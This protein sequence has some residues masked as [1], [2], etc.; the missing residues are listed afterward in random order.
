MWH[1]SCCNDECPETG[2]W[3]IGSYNATHNT[4]TRC[5]RQVNRQPI[6]TTKEQIGITSARIA[7]APCQKSRHVCDGECRCP[8]KQSPLKEYAIFSKTNWSSHYNA[9]AY[10]SE[11]IAFDLAVITTRPTKLLGDKSAIADTWTG[12]A[13]IVSTIS[14]RELCGILFMPSSNQLDLMQAVREFTSWREN[15][16]RTTNNTIIQNK[17]LFLCCMR[18]RVSS[19]SSQYYT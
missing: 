13:M 14:H 19:F 8:T 3:A 7:Y 2:T 4:W 10:A 9:V 12:L 18:L 16:A 11:I 1:C 15:A 6:T 5:W 17:T